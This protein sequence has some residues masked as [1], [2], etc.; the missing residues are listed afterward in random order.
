MKKYL[1]SGLGISNGGVGRLMRN[2]MVQGEAAGFLTISR[3]SPQPIGQMLNKRQYL[4]VAVEMVLRI[5]DNVQFAWKV[6]GLSHAVIVFVHPQTAGFARLLNMVRKNQ[7][8]LYVMDNSF[9][10]IK[11]YNLHPE[12]EVE[13]LRCVSS[14]RLALPACQ[15]FPVKIE[16]SK[17][18]EYLE[19]LEAIAHQITFLAQNVSQAELVRARFG[20]DTKIRIVGLDTGELEQEVRERNSSSSQVIPRY[21]LVFHGAPQLAKG[22]RYFIE[23]SE[24][25]EGFTAFI[26]SSRT[27]CEQVIGRAITAN[28]ITF[29]ECTWETGLKAAIQTSEL[30]LNPSLWSAPIEGAL[31]KSIF[32]AKRVAVVETE[33]GYEKEFVSSDAFVRLPR[34]VQAAAVVVQKLLASPVTTFADENKVGTIFPQVPVNIFELVVRSE[35]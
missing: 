26:P 33:F 15:P 9:F 11:S 13:C 23:L 3:R 4:R 1:V 29:K 10:C 12:L 22:I 16:K 17:N 5:A 2:L 35:A 24:L 34:N 25:L 20:P 19:R 32:F 28:N 14:P 18:L 27:Q 6:K 31:Q 7:V 30:V 21:D 8:Y